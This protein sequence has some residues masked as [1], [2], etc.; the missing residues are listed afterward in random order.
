MRWFILTAYRQVSHDA[1]NF[2]IK[3]EFTF[4]KPILFQTGIRLLIKSKIKSRTHVGHLT[5][6]ILYVGQYHMLNW[7]CIGQL[8]LQ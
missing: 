5:C 4:P 7:C 1:G 3:F 8:T 2:H 6:M